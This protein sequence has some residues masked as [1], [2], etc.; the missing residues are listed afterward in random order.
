MK[1]LVGIKGPELF[2]PKKKGLAAFIEKLKWALADKSVR[3]EILSIVADA[4]RRGGGASRALRE[5]R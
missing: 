5:S 3:A 4:T 1:N 2:I